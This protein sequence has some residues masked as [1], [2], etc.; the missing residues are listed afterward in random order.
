MRACTFLLALLTVSCSRPQPERAAPA[1]AASPAKKD[2]QVPVQGEVHALRFE[3]GAL[4]FCDGRGALRVDLKSGDVAAASHTCAKT[5]PNTACAGLGVEVAVRSPRGAPDDIVDAGGTSFP[6][7]GHVRDCGAEERAIGVVTG[8]G[9]LL[10]DL[11]TEKTKL[12]SERARERVALGSGWIAWT[13][14]AM[15]R[16]MVRPSLR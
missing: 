6:V 12:L 4:L 10:I 7:E 3:N 9:L 8:A 13:E 1:A 5:E 14:G 11:T 15:L 16:A 2:V